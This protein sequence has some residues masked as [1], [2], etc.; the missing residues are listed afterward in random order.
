MALGAWPS[1]C[2]WA[3]SCLCSQIGRQV[4]TWVKEMSYVHQRPGQAPEV[5]NVDWLW[6]DLRN[7][8]PSEEEH[9]LRLSET[10]APLLAS[11]RCARVKG[12]GHSLPQV[13]GQRDCYYQQPSPKT[14]IAVCAAHPASW[15]GRKFY[16]RVPLP[17]SASLHTALRADYSSDG[18]R[19]QGSLFGP[20]SF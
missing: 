14:T 18:T 3:L 5:T 9:F 4:L 12:A 13:S 20:D 19:K 10:T 8:S 11:M 16:M 17:A 6:L 15:V 7:H 1:H 2:S